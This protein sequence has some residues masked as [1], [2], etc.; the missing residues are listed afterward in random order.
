MFATRYQTLSDARKKQIYD[1]LGEEGLQNGGAGAGPS[2]PSN[3]GFGGF[4]GMGGMGRGMAGGR[5][6]FVFNMDDPRI[7]PRQRQHFEEGFKGRDGA[8]SFDAFV[9]MMGG[10]GGIPRTRTNGKDRQTGAQPGYRNIPT[11]SDFQKTSDFQKVLPCTLEQLY[12]GCIRKM[13]ITKR[14]VSADGGG[15]QP[16]EKILEVEVQA[17]WKKGTKIT[18][19]GEGDDQLGGGAQ[20]LVF[21]IEEKPHEYFIRDGDDLVY[22]AKI[23]SSSAQKDLKITVPH[24]DGRSITV[25]MSSAELRKVIIGEGMPIR[26]M[27]GSKGN[28]IIHLEVQRNKDSNSK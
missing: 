5:S 12:T 27:P 7:G 15:F 2:G 26:K 16:A 19:P 21:V 10:K 4:G 28:M 8:S 18:F 3:P 25:T 6:R 13:K 23:P 14:M 20:D 22:K 17:G 24:L 1:Q 11:A 9:D